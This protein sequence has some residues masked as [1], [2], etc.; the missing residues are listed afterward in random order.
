MSWNPQQ[1]EKFKAERFAPFE[2]LLGLISIEPDLSLVDLG[3]GTGE[4]TA[5]LRDALP[6]SEALGVDSSAE[7][8]VK[9]REWADDSLH[10]RQ[11]PLENLKGS[12]DLVFSHAALQ[13]VDHHPVLFASLW[14]RVR[15]GG[16]L[17]IQMP[18]NHSHPTHQLLTE[19][20]AEEPFY[21]AL[22]GWSRQSPV[23][24]IE[25]YAQGLYELGASQQVVLEKVYPHLLDSSADLVEWVKGTA[26]LPYLE[27]LGPELEAVF[28]E[29][30]SQRL[31]ALFPRSPVFYGFRR[32]LIWARKPL[33]S[34]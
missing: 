24:G 5:R 27:R 18:S 7:M 22:K 33:S 2:D 23:L 21:S 19:L 28:L 17:A 16:Q 14:E 13:W 3:C 9:A 11:T 25:A 10:F 8:L 1:Y 26:L 20:A 32:I 4:L 31:A 6:G 15:P 30:Y 12:W 34:E 29:R